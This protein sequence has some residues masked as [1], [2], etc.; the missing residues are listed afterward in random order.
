MKNVAGHTICCVA[1]YYPKKYFTCFTTYNKLLIHY[2]VIIPV[3]GVNKEIGWKG[4]HG[5]NMTAEVLVFKR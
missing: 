2:S 5:Q 1:L 3:T 4:I